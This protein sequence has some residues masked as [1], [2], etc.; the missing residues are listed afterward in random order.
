[1]DME[2]GVSAALGITV[3][4]D[5]EALVLV[6]IGTEQHQVAVPM[7]PEIALAYAKGMVDM[8]REAQDLQE[9]LDTL[10]PGD[11]Q[12]RLLDIQKKFAAPNN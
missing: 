6:I 2:Q 3:D 10:A 7:T 12:E 4:N 8:A 9:E 11:L 5:G 1:M